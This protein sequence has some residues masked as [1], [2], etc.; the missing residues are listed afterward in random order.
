MPQESVMLMKTKFAHRPPQW[1]LNIAIP[2]WD[3]INRVDPEPDDSPEPTDDVERLKGAL[4]KEREQARQYAKEL[5]ALKSQLE[6]FSGLDPEKAR[7][8]LEIAKRQQEIEAQQA[9]IVAQAKAETEGQFRPRIQEL[10]ERLNQTATEYTNFKRDQLLQDEF[11][12]AEGLPGEFVA[13][14]HALQGRVAFGPDGKL[15][16]VGPDGQPEFVVDQGRSV[17]KTVRQLIEE[18]KGDPNHIWFARHFKG[19]EKSGF[20]ITGVP[21]GNDPSFAGLD[22]WEKVSRIRQNQGRA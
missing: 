19:N 2:Q 17:P 3:G 16:V 7:E 1:L 8:A 20:G 13:V 9:Q 5:K 10:E 21:G 18:L 14:A 4:G 22:P 15:Q 6:A 11:L 12:K